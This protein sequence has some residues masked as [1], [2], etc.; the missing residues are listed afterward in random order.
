MVDLKGNVEASC[1]GLLGPLQPSPEKPSKGL[2]FAQRPTWLRAGIQ[3]VYSSRVL[4]IVRGP[5]INHPDPLGRQLH[6]LPH[7]PAALLQ[8]RVLCG[9]KPVIGVG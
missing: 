6:T 7:D 1:D 2:R 8:D 4:I 3:D 9:Q 5:C